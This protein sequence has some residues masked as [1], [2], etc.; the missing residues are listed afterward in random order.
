M[1][2][3][4]E[5]TKAMMKMVFGLILSVMTVPLLFFI[6]WTIFRQVPLGAAIAAVI[7]Y[8][9][10]RYHYRLIDQNYQA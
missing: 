5:E 1:V 7:V 8:M 9:L 4:E 10:Q 6:V 3:E 2:E